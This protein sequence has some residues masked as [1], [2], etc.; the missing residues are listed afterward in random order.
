MKN[1][2]RL[3]ILA[4]LAMLAP[5]GFA[6]DVTTKLG[7]ESAYVSYGTKFAEETWVPMI[8]VSQ[9]DYYA[10]IWGYIPT[11]TK[12]SFEG[13]WDFFAG[14]T[15][16]LNKLVSLD[17]GATIYQY[18]RTDVDATTLEGFL[19]LNF[20]LPLS[21]K[22]KLYYDITVKNWIGEAMVSHTVTLNKTTALVL[23]GQGGFRRPDYHNAWFYATAKADLMFTLAPKTKL[24]VGVRSTNNTDGAAVGHSLINWY[25]MSVAHTW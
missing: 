5:T 21:P 1:F 2:L 10:G 6:A 12:K 4:S 23:V 25:G 18:P 14:R 20:D 13:E 19:W 11:H 3:K 24:F 22:L 9:G 17:L 8:D 15:F 16:K 7:F